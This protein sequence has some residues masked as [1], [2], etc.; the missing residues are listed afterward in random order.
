[1]NLLL[2]INDIS[3]SQIYLLE[4][5][6]NIIMDGVFTKILYS[7][8]CMSM[9]GL[10]IDFPIKNIMTNKIQSKNIIQLD[11]INNKDIFQKLIDI[12]KQLLFYYVQYFQLLHSDFQSTEKRC[13]IQ[14]KNMVFTLKT[15]LQSGSIKYYKAYDSYSKPGSFF[16]KISGIWENQREI[17]IT[18]KII[19]YHKQI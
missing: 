10:Y 11:I 1:M 14:N 2:S 6:T 7:N 18:F 4:K 9:N 5:K 12:E 19:E 17:G 15:Q 16:I 8:H 13:N 3:L